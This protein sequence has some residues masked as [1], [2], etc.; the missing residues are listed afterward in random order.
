[1]RDLAARVAAR[2]P[3]IS[4]T[5]RGFIG[6]KLR[7][8]PA[9][10]ALLALG[11]ARPLGAVLDLGC[12]RGQLAIALLLAGVAG[13]VTGLD[14]DAAKIALARR[15]AEGLPARFEV[16]DLV[17]AEIPPAETVLLVDVLLQMPPAGQAALLAR[18]LASA[19][20]RVVIRAFDPERGWRSAFGFAMERGRRLLGGDRGS[21]GALAPRPV[22]EIAAPFAAAGYAVEVTPCWAG[23]PLPNVL[24]VA[25]RP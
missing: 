20:R 3:G 17:A 7:A 24:L 9:T 21:A 19:P 2:Y 8:D 1:M 10:A 14:I 11:A 12:G 6:G 16:A 23:T 5:E 15:A 4:R 13:R 22:G 25:E 18:I